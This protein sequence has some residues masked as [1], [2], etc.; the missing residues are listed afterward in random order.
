MLNRWVGGILRGTFRAEP[1]PAHSADLYAAIRQ[2]LDAGINVPIRIEFVQSAGGHFIL[3]LD[4]R[5]QTDGTYYLLYD[6]Y[7]GVCGYVPEAN[8]NR[9]SMAPLKAAWQIHVSHY[10]PFVAG[11]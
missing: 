2:Q 8:L 10:Y 3:V 9:G 7:D 5:Q 11:R 6:P 4:Y 1:A